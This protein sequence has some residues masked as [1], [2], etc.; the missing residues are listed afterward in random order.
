MLISPIYLAGGMRDG[1]RDLFFEAF[2][3]H[4]FFDPSNHGLGGEKEYTAWDLAH[5]RKA[6]T[7]IAYMSAD[8]PSGYGLCLEV[9]YAHA[10]GKHI[11]F[12]GTAGAERNKYFGMV[13]AI[14]HEN[15]D[16]IGDAISA[17]RK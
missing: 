8:N 2:P 11:I 7:V 16:C 1:W 4:E 17:A 12:C 10:L 6:Q 15:Y 13:R 3:E 14:A 5:I 9:G